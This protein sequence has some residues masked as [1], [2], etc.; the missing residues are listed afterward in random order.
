MTKRFTK[1]YGESL[2]RSKRF[3]AASDKTKLLYVYL[4]SNSHSNTIGAYTIPD[5]YALA[6]L[7]WPIADYRAARDQLADAGLIVFDDDTSVVYVANW[8]KHSPPQNEK[9]AQGCQRMISELESDLVADVV[10]RDFDDAN[11]E[12]LAG[13]NPLD[14]PKVSTALMQSRLMGGRR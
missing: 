11:N 2:W 13:R 5:G 4:L 12:R 14:D 8:F 10:Q 3:L 1:V 9:H 7:G 6:D